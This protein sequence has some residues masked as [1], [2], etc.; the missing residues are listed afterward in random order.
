[1]FRLCF[2]KH[3]EKPLGIEFILLL[4]VNRNRVMVARRSK[5]VTRLEIGGVHMASGIDNQGYPAA[6]K[7]KG[8]LIVVFVI[9]ESLGS[10]D[11]VGYQQVFST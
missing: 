1:M 9:P 3:S 4:S 6:M 8:Q 2:F 5:H 7:F 11:G 10:H